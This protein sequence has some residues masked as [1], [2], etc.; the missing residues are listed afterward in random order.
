LTNLKNFAKL[1]NLVPALQIQHC[2]GQKDFF[3]W[4]GARSEVC[5]LGYISDEQQRQKKKYSG[6]EREAHNEAIS[7]L[8]LLD[9]PQRARLRRRA[10]S[11]SS[12]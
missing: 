4:L 10:L 5:P 6:S 7:A 11:S 1:T 9:V 8:L 2:I 12:L 3:F